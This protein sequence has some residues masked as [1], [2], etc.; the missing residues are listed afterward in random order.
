VKH[1]DEFLL[2]YMACALWASID[3]QP[4]GNGGPPMDEK[5]CVHDFTP[6]AVDNM[7]TDCRDF[8]RRARSPL[9]A[10]FN[11][12]GYSP[13]RAGNDFWL[14]RNHHGAGYWD[15]DELTARGIGDKLTTHAHSFGEASIY[16]ENGK[17]HHD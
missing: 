13:E 3:E 4:D 5:Y 9:R 2:G 6:E 12:V 15:R 17:V 7:R 16:A 11:R 1:L 10:A 8:L 14:T